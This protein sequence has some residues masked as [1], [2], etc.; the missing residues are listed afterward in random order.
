MDIG[1]L[2]SEVVIQHLFSKSMVVLVVVELTQNR[3][4]N[5]K[6]EER[7]KLIS[8]PPSGCFEELQR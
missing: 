2:Y 3:L 5:W 7:T 6:T 4:G 1:F 8:L